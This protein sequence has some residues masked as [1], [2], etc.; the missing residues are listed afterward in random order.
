[1]KQ[2]RT[3]GSQT[4]VD[5]EPFPGPQCYGQPRKKPSQKKAM[6]FYSLS[7]ETLTLRGHPA[8]ISNH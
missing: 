6:G 1:M 7:T 8:P 2:S 4:S 3:G 5:W